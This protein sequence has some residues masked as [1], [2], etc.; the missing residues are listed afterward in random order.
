M[1]FKFKLIAL[2]LITCI[3]FNVRVA[4]A[5]GSLQDQINNN[6]D[7]INALEKE[8]DDVNKKKSEAQK[9][10]DKLLSQ[11]Q[12]KE[13]ELNASSKK[14]NDFQSKINELQKSIDDIE[15]KVN[16]MDKEIESKQN[17]ILEKKEEAKERE[18]MLGERLRGYYKMDMSSQFIYIIFNSTS[19]TD[20][21]SNVFNINKLINMDNVILEDI[22]KIRDDLE[23][24]QKSLEDQIASLEEEKKSVVSK[25]HE[26]KDMQSEFVKEKNLYQS[27]M[28]QL[29]SLEN[30][31]DRIVKNLSKEEKELQDKIGDLN[32]FNKEL[33]DE[34]DNIFGN[35][36]GG[37]GEDTS[38]ESFL[39]PTS[40]TL[41]SKYGPRVHPI[42]GANG[43][44]TGIDIANSTGTPI[45]ASKSGTVVEARTMNGYGKT[46]IID[47]G[48]G[49]QTLYAHNSSLSVTKGQKVQRGQTIAKMGSTGNSTGP[50]LHFEIRINGKHTDP[51][52]F[53][54]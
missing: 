23:K 33:Q 36:G 35:I 10:L 14:V 4:N 27:Q 51:M 20:L 39:R 53:I 16:K 40:G 32:D 6:N 18:K 44:H 48:G 43:F 30:S 45:Y 49:Y 34:I 50:H 46:I 13:K 38:G 8:K 24:E 1:K 29:T 15:A 42:T 9:E 26:L 11:V 21:V 19:F 17:K 12:Q 5:T 54:K 52:K 22:E 2:T 37:S 47:H 25:Q 41:T 3:L 31:K 28:D 7:K